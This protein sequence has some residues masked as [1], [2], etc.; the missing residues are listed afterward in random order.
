MGFWGD[1]KNTFSGSDPQ[2]E[3]NAAVEQQ[4]IRRNR[5]KKEEGVSAELGYADKERQQTAE[6]NV[7]DYKA[8]R[9][10]AVDPYYKTLDDSATD[11]QQTYKGT[12][13][14]RQRDIMDTAQRDAS[15]A[16][17]LGQAGDPNNA[18][19]QSYRNLYNKEAQGVG[20]RGRADA[21][22]MA[23]LG[24]QATAQQ[25]GGLPMT[26]AQLQA[27]QGMNLAQSGQ[28]Y[29][30]AQQRMDKLREQGIDTGITESSNQYERGRQAKSRYGD[31]VRDYEDAGRRN[32]NEQQDIG[33]ERFNV[34]TG[35]AKE[36][37]GFGTG[38]SE[39]QHGARTDAAMRE[40]QRIQDEYGGLSAEASGRAER[41]RA[42]RENE[43]KMWR[44]GAEVAGRGVAGMA[45][46]GMSEA[47]L[48][49][50]Q[51]AESR[52]Q[53]R[54]NR[55]QTGWERDQYAKYGGGV[56]N[57]AYDP[58]EAPFNPEEEAPGKNTRMRPS[59]G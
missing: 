9:D 28:A 18:V 19:Q 5:A 58:Y 30:N 39:L 38:L 14:P 7:G 46:G 23:A 59:Y 37:L 51:A 43:A 3:Q 6:K 33:A 13:Q 45:T 22:V 55:E 2:A 44:T 36:N 52:A 11:A 8:Q 21:G 4:V 47:A 57:M 12:T 34:G 20:A 10:K 42:E 1:I 32:R 27:A 53:N 15:Q 29:A 41:T 54:E 24:S 25:L 35:V 26:G 50:Q 31:T 16:M 48:A 17:T 40:Q 49:A 56:G